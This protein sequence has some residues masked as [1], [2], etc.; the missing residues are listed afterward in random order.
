MDIIAAVEQISSRIKRKLSTLYFR[1]MLKPLYN[2][3]FNKYGNRFICDGLLFNTKI[4]VGGKNNS[5]I[6]EKGAII[7]NT[8]ICITGFNHEIVIHN[9]VRFVENGRIRIEDTYN[10]LEIGENTN[11]IG[12]FFSIADNNTEIKLG[13]SCLISANVIIRTSDSHSI[14]NMNGERINNGKSVYLKDHVWIGYGSTI[15]KGSKIGADSVVGS[16]SLV[17]GL[18][19]PNN[20]VIAGIP[21]KIVKNDITWTHERIL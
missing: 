9:N 7:K 21:A 8:T 1:F 15:L 14:C 17:A 11:I 19:T 18:N 10:R 6:I 20:C 4:Q 2:Y 13:K 5:I 12:C 3:R 16:N